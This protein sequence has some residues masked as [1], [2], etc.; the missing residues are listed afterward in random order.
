MPL[1]TNAV[2]SSVCHN[3]AA[4][5]LT[6]NVHPAVSSTMSRIEAAAPASVTATVLGILT[7]RSLAQA[8]SA[9]SV[10]STANA[11]STGQLYEGWPRSAPRGSMNLQPRRR[12]ASPRR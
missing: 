7:H 2:K 5:C 6:P 1:R 9:D 11:V 3:W 4:C 10:K 8:R 12:S